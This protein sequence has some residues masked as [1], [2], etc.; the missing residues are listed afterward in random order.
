MPLEESLAL[1]RQLEQEGL[2]SDDAFRLLSEYVANGQ[3][4]ESFSG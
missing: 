1:Q 4:W 2:R 3:N